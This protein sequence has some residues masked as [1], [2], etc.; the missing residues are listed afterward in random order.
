VMPGGP[1]SIALR[2]GAT[3][4]PCA[5]YHDRRP[6]HWRAVVHPPLRPEPSGDS[7]KDTQV[8]TQRLAAEFERLIA[9]APEQWHVLSPYF[10]TPA[11]GPVAA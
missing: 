10:R 4:L 6:G 3:L 2:T 8:L 5:V 11:G 9:A 1:A 7:R